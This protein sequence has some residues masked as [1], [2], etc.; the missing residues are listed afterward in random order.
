VADED[1]LQVL[2][3]L[4]ARAQEE[5]VEGHGNRSFQAFRPTQQYSREARGPCGTPGL[6]MLGPC[7]PGSPAMRAPSRR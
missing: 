2:V 5:V 3:R 7:V 6:R 4:V 1:L